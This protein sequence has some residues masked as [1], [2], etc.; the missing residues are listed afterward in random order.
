[1]SPHSAIEW[2]LARS[3][4]IDNLKNAILG[5]YNIIL[6]LASVLENGGA[7]KRLLDKIIN[8]CMFWKMVDLP[9]SLTLQVTPWSTCVRRF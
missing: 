9:P 2:A 7:D 3:T 1:M 6:A 4:L 8:R 5:N